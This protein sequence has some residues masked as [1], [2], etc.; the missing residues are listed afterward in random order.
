MAILGPLH[1]H[2]HFRT[3]FSIPMKECAEILTGIALTL[4]INLG[5]TNNLN[6]E[7]YD[8]WAIYFPLT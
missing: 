7:P 3:G 4:Q 6:I 5:R 1:L 2:V 8:L